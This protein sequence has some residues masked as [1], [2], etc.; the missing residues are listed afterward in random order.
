MQAA[1]VAVD[2]ELTSFVSRLRPREIV[3]IGADAFV[4]LFLES[5]EPFELEVDL[6]DDGVVAGRTLLREVSEVGEVNRILVRHDG[7]RM[8]LLVDGEQILGAKQNR[9]VNASFL[10][11]SGQ[12]VAVP[13]SCV[14]RGRWEYASRT[15]APSET[16]LTGIARSRMVSRVTQS[17]IA[18]QG[19][20]A[21]QGAVWRD[22]DEYLDRSRVVS[23]TSALEDAL[24][25]RRGG[26]EQSLGMLRPLPGQ[27]GVA[28]VREGALLLLD[29]FGSADL[30]ARAHRKVL[31]GMLADTRTDGEAAPGA[32][33]TVQK[34]LEELTRIE[35]HRAAAPG[36]GETLRA[37]SESFSA[38][39]LVHDDAVYHLVVAAA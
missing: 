6:L 12:E 8:L 13:V 17:V 18:G 21:G 16:T 34:T 7:E 5:R 33:E 3:T 26:N 25:T 23:R 32:I 9:V 28:M 30:Y 22:V 24:V 27:V 29:A 14:E 11:P 10:V 1:R 19:Y 2:D 37:K 15:F 20:D 39:A 4:R 38:S 31:R 35:A 36:C